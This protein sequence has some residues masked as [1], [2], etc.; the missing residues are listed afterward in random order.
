VVGYLEE[1]TALAGRGTVTPSMSV[2]YQ[3]VTRNRAGIERVHPYTVDDPLAPGSVIRVSGRDWLIERIEGE[4]AFAQPARYRLRL[5]H[6][7]G[8]EELGAMRRF[9]SDAPRLGHA[10]STVEYGAPASWEVMEERLAVADDGAPYLDLVAERDYSE[11]EALAGEAPEVAALPNH[12]LEHALAAREANLPDAA[13]A[14]LSRAER[15]GLAV[16]LVALEPGEESDWTEAAAY[17][18]ALSFEE[19]EDDLFELCGVDLVNDQRETWLDAVKERLREDARAF[20]SD[21]EGEHKEIE[22]WDFQDG[23][24]FAS[25]G[26]TDDEGDPNKGHGWMCRLVD[27]GALAAAGFARV[28]KPDLSVEAS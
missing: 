23:R 1:T 12:E 22:E 7:D 4:R 18:D 21:I 2:S 25:L 14:T 19:I 10:F 28:W 3:V 5:R 17:I 6:P 27:A 20:R 16:E 13:V 8:R 15:D 24:I 26:T 9:R 11:A